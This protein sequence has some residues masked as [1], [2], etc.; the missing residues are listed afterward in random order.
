MNQKA[1]RYLPELHYFFDQKD[2]PT[3]K[4]TVITAKKVGEWCTYYKAALITPVQGMKDTEREGKFP[5]QPIEK[6]QFIHD[7]IAWLISSSVPM[8]SNHLF[9]LFLDDSEILRAYKPRKFSHP[10]DTCCWDMT[11]T[12]PQFQELETAWEDNGLPRDLFYEEGKG[13]E[14]IKPPGLIARFFGKLGFT[15]KNSK[16]Y[17]PKRWEKKQQQERSVKGN[18][19]KV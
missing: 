5:L 16:V 19:L 15:S 8:T 9:T 12:E 13:T 2:F 7:L 18:H 14:I 3:E 11:L 17:S 10:D 1:M 4:A 6:Q